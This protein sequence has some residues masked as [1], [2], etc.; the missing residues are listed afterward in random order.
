[1]EDLPFC[2]NQILGD[3]LGKDHLVL[4]SL[5]RTSL[6]GFVGQFDHSEAPGGQDFELSSPVSVGDSQ[7]AISFDWWWGFELVDH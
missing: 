6:R 3:H 2:H 4:S 5:V 7:M 1:M